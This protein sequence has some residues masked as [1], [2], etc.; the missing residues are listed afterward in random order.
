MRCQLLLLLL[1]L[2]AAALLLPAGLDVQQ[3]LHL[4]QQPAL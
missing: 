4:H 2:Y 3:H 1:L